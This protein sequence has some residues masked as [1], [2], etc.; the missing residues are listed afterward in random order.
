MGEGSEPMDC[1]EAA[2]ARRL[3]Q[4]TVLITA[5]IDAF[6]ANYISKACT[7]NPA[8]LALLALRTNPAADADCGFPLPTNARKSALS[9]PLSADS[10]SPSPS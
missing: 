6:I 1:E 8:F 10:L 4:K 9:T 3:Q 5:L 2:A 7:H